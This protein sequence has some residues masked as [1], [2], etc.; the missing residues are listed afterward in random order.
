LLKIALQK[1]GR[2]HNDSIYLIKECGI[3]LNTVKQLKNTALNFPL[4]LFFLRDDDIPQL[5]E[6]GVADIGI[7][8]NNIYMEKEKKIKIIDELGFCKCRLS[9][10]FPKEFEYKDIYDLNN[11]KIATSYPIL[12]KKFLK[13]NQINAYIYQL[14]GS[15]EIAPS[16]GLSDCICDLVSSGETLF[17]NGLIEKIIILECEA[18][19]AANK[20][21]NVKTIKNLL[22][23]IKKAKNMIFDNTDNISDV[24]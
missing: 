16:I 23:I 10:A 18:V 19:L 17:M 21:M 11:K 12:L 6:Y 2:L 14:S 24:L 5:L 13:L 22:V 9:I 8:G 15:V 20:N 7:I 1:S 4:D 3:Q